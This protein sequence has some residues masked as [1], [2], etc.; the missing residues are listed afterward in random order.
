MRK[1]G[2][3]LVNGATLAAVV[4]IFGWA[5][6]GLAAESISPNSITTSIGVGESFTIN[7]TVTLGASGAT[8]VDVFFLADNTGSMVGTVASA[9]SGASAILNG[10]PDTYRFGVGRYY[11]DPSEPSV[12]PATSFNLLTN[13]TADKTA[14]QSGI[15][16]WNASGGGDIPEANFYALQQTANNASWD[17]GSRHI[18]V[19]FGDAPS[20]TETTTQQEAIDALERVDAKVVA[21]NNGVAG[22]G[23]DGLYTGQ[24]AGTHQASDIIA[25]TGGSLTNNFLGLTGTDFVNKVTGEISTAA[26]TLDLNFYSTFVGSGLGLTFACTDSLGCTGVTGGESR[27]FDLTITGLEPGTYDFNVGAVGVGA[28]EH[29]SIT[30]AA[31]PEP[32]TYALMLAGLAMLGAAYRRRAGH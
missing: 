15:N 27:T 31:V 9:Q 6:V 25:Q 22:S 18:V 32:E 23:I 5:S 1:K 3:S 14:V 28:L 8:A 13:L 2:S 19:W 11:G 30:V 17:A 24:P 26:S 21:F 20:H 12:T 7:K 4:V 16:L 29:D 10:L